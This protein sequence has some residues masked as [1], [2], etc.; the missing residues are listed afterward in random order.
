[1]I[2]KAEYFHHFFGMRYTI[3]SVPATVGLLAARLFLGSLPFEGSYPEDPLRYVMARQAS[4]EE[5][6]RD[7]EKSL[8]AYYRRL[9]LGLGQ[10]EANSSRLMT[11]SAPRADGHGVLPLLLSHNATDPG[12]SRSRS[13]VYSWPVTE[14]LIAAELKKINELYA[15]LRSADDLDAIRRRAVYAR[16]AGAYSALE[17]HRENI[18]AHIQYNRFWQRIIATHH[19][20]YDQQTTLYEKVVTRDALDEIANAL[21]GIAGTQSTIGRALALGFSGLTN[22][23][24]QKATALN[25]ELERQ[26]DAIDPP[27]FIHV[28]RRNAHNWIV[29]VPFSTD[30]D[31][32]EFLRSFK[33]VV[34]RVWYVRDGND[35]FRVEVSFLSIVKAELHHADSA[36]GVDGINIERQLGW[37]RGKTALLTAGGT[38]THARGAAVILGSEPLSPRVL[39]HELGHVLGFRDGYFRGYRDIGVD[40]LE[41]MEADVD[42]LDIMDAPA[43]GKV[44]KSH[45]MRLFAAIGC[46]ARAEENF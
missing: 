10:S 8:D 23:L 5:S 20:E 29:H 7:Y 11:T 25:R 14:K 3:L 43:T 36:F 15:E 22:R 30:I 13:R 42:P 44:T 24:R 39:A 9:Q 35:E 19:W 38:T 6:Y 17:E 26:T 2:V 40:G 27:P 46:G 37:V 45:F 28:E 1:L 33:T 12:G 18:V 21:K 34:E 16:L 4:V 41:I 32:P 31:D